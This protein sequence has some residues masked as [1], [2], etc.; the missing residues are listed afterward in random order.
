MDRLLNLFSDHLLVR[1][2]FSFLYFSIWFY[3]IKTKGKS[4]WES[5]KGDDGILQVS[6][7]VVLVGIIGYVFMIPLDSIWGI[8]ASDKVWYGIDVIMAF[9]LGVNAYMKKK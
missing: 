3:L 7:L 6:E 4:L 5:I 1:L 9:S 2:V 8:I